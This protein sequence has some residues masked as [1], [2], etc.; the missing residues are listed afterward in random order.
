MD[1]MKE[2]AIWMWVVILWASI[3]GFCGTAILSVFV[4]WGI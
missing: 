2:A 4:Q 3:V 1:E